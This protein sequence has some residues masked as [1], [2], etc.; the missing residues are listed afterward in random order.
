[1][2]KLKKEKRLKEKYEKIYEKF[3]DYDELGVLKP[4][5]EVKNILT[6]DLVYRLELFL[7]VKRN[8][9][10]TNEMVNL[11]YFRYLQRCVMLEIF[12]PKN[13]NKSRSEIFFD[14]LLRNK[15][16][17]NAFEKELEKDKNDNK[18]YSYQI[19]KKY[20]KFF[21]KELVFGEDINR[22]IYSIEKQLEPFFV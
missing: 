14:Y 1:M 22:K 12:D 21:K 7:S 19:P 17:I 2:S 16:E 13:I 11:C 6:K 15:N 8:K 18:Y 5:K 20:D 10:F 4:Y 3:K 9:L